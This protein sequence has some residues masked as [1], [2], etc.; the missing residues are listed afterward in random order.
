M[1]TGIDFLEDS[2]DLVTEAF[3]IILLLGI[4]INCSTP[5]KVFVFGVFT[6]DYN[7]FFG[8]VVMNFG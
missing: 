2:N 3:G 5:L 1:F 6:L 8:V 7:L 4:F